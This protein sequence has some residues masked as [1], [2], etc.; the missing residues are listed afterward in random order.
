MYRYK[1][2][3]A[4]ILGAFFILCAGL[5]TLQQ[6]DEYCN[7]LNNCVAENADKLAGE[8][9]AARYVEVGSKAYE[10]GIN[11]AQ[12]MAL[13]RYYRY[14]MGE[15]YGFNSP[16][17]TLF[18]TGPII[19]K[20]KEKYVDGYDI[21]K[22]PVTV[23]LGSPLYR[24]SKIIVPADFMNKEQLRDFEKKVKAG[25][26]DLHYFELSGYQQGRFFYPTKMDD[27]KFDAKPVGRKVKSTAIQDAQIITPSGKVTGYYGKEKKID[28]DD[29]WDPESYRVYEA[30]DGYLIDESAG[31]VA[32]DS[33]LLTSDTY[34]IQNVNK[35]FV[36][37]VGINAPTL[38]PVV[39]S[40]VP[41]YIILFA[42]VMALG[43]VLIFSIGRKIENNY[44]NE[45]R[46]RLIVDAIGHEL[47]TPLSIIKNY[48]EILA[49]EEDE[50]KRREY[51][52]VIVDESDAMNF[53]VVSMIE[54]SKME[55]GTY[56]MELNDF[57]VGKVA[58]QEVAHYRSLAKKKNVEIKLEVTGDSEIYADKK[59]VRYILANYISNAVKH[60]EEG[61]IVDV[62]IAGEEGLEITVRNQGRELTKEEQSKIWEAYTSSG[63]GLAIVKQACE[64]HGGTWGCRNDEGGVVFT[65]TIPR[66]NVEGSAKARTG[67]V[68]RMR[69]GGVNLS[70][71]DAVAYGFAIA[72]VGV[73]TSM[74]IFMQLGI[75]STLI[76]SVF[77][78]S[79]IITFIGVN[80]LWKN[81]IGSGFLFGLGVSS[82]VLVGVMIFQR[83]TG[84][85]TFSSFVPPILIV[86]QTCI[87]ASTS[88]LASDVAE[89]A[90]DRRK[91]GFLKKVRNTVVS[92]M[93]L[94]SAIFILFGI[95]K[96]IPEFAMGILWAGVSILISL[97]WVRVYKEY[98]VGK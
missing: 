94:L 70:G 55:A 2:N 76:L 46:R 10:H 72:G 57:S 12:V 44:E 60:A 89:A 18:K 38:L 9:R 49:D 51:A 34:T 32:Y 6:K 26:S 59:L 41:F 30:I 37:Y 84:N 65:A 11:S 74:D 31:E 7:E 16:T 91:A 56:P 29:S 78:V 14:Q 50:G 62:K 21:Y 86:L 73:G 48:G 17:V 90:G 25:E 24:N 88:T 81:K 40:L 64:L 43:A 87:A 33:R 39:K 8:I 82:L 52:K 95:P 20:G 22:P 53:D 58:E 71:L 92:I 85:Y 13:I 77:T 80:Q 47:K 15:K 93:G 27:K 36:L 68:L 5:V 28:Y 63:I 98:N 1:R 96:F 23:I 19:G 97:T 3:V 79:A 67:R 66:S 54:L 83:M 61:S 69:S 4:L 45:K 75:T 35:D 42:V